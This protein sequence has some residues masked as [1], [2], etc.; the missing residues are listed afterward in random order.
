[1]RAVACVRSHRPG[2]G[3][4]ACDQRTRAS[5]T[6]ISQAHL[7]RRAGARPASPDGLL[8]RS[9]G[10]RLAGAQAGGHSGHSCSSCDS[11][12]VWTRRPVL[13][14][15]ETTDAGGCF[16]LLQT[17]RPELWT[18]RGL[19]HGS[20]Y[21]LSDSCSCRLR[22]RD[23]GAVLGG[24]PA[25]PAGLSCA[26]TPGEHVETCRDGLGRDL[27]PRHPV[28]QH[29]GRQIGL[30]TAFL[31]ISP[32]VLIRSGHCLGVGFKMVLIP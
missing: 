7:R 1:V 6:V 4:E 9:V 27:G 24:A 25:D 8:R 16:S 10:G 22:R 11:R 19:D 30:H 13:A 20:Q 5:V 29:Q 31:A 3:A 17:R 21:A 15:R 32:C 28:R 26:R 12:Q 2:A 14:G 23:P 18:L